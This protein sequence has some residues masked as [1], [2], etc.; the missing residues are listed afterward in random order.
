[1]NNDKYD[2][3]KFSLKVKKAT[4]EFKESIVLYKTIFILFVLGV[5]ISEGVIIGR[6]NNID[7][8]YELIKKE[9]E[10]EIIH[11]RK[12]NEEILQML[13][14]IRDE[15]KEKIQA[16]NISYQQQKI[17]VENLKYDGIH[18]YTDLSENSNIS[19]ED[20]DK[21]INYYEENIRHTAFVNK[22]YAFVEAAKLSGLNP[23]YLF[24]HAA[25][26]SDY[27]MSEIAQY[28]NNY[29]GIGAFDSNPSNAYYMGDSVEEGII[30]GAIWIRKNYYDKGMETLAE[31]NPVYCTNNNWANMISSI[32]NFAISLI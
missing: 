7:L 15:Q 12:V 2:N 26:E 9:H 4:T 13:K 11:N 28:N 18:A 20:M 30:N 31:M 1:M 25:C 17:A 10:E 21:I 27:G 5:I 6:L 14:T 19:V 22:G 29:F 32:A 24:A 23:I 16:Q 3:A 8:Q